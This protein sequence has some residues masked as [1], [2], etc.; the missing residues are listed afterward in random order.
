MRTASARRTTLRSRL[1]VTAVVCV[2]AVAATASVSGIALGNALSTSD[3][4]ERLAE[5]QSRHQDVDMAHD[6]VQAI[7]ARTALAGQRG[8]L[9]T[10][11]DQ[12]AELDRQRL[13]VD[14]ALGEVYELL[15]DEPGLLAPEQQ[16]SGDLGEYLALADRIVNSM[17]G[18]AY[19]Q[20][21]WS[22]FGDA[23]DELEATLATVTEQFRDAIAQATVRGDR[24]KRTAIQV[25]TLA[26]L[27]AVLTIVT[28][29][30]LLRRS[31]ARTIDRMSDVADAV[32][33]G[34]LSRRNA[35]TTEDELGR[36]AQRFDSV[37]ASLDAMVARLTA[38]AARTS[39]SHELSSVLDTVDAE[40]DLAGVAERAMKHATEA[41]VEL[42]LAD[43]SR[44][45]LQRAAGH[46]VHGAPGCG[47]VSPFDCAAVRRGDTVVFRSSEGLDACP[48]LAGRC[49]GAETAVCAPVGFMGRA[50]G[51]LHATRP[52]EEPFTADEVERLG[53][54]ATALGTRV[55]TIRAFRTSQLRAATDG[56]TGLLNRRSLEERLNLLVSELQPF[57]LA[58]ADLD[59]FK[60][61]N[62]TYGHETGDRALRMF[63]EV[64]RT[65]LRSVDL[66]ARWGGEEFTIAF[67][68]VTATEA[69]AACDRVR[70]SL[71][72]AS[73]SGAVP[74]FTVSFGVVDATVAGGVREA[75]RLADEALYAAKNAGRDRVV[76]GPVGAGVVA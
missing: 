18:T 59:H 17:G 75:L 25:L 23:S 37:A 43:S 63:A 4:I 58:V 34:D 16:A 31:L 20:Q 73:S 72:V 33:G 1:A 14:D 27:A 13:V 64:L 11:N 38:D 71:L 3:R 30:V 49:A 26:A 44:A 55:G 5:A 8:D 2:V 50:V 46:P 24:A 48:K 56:L 45:H 10:L 41:K 70:E 62:D 28:A 40:D 7:V 29:L 35:D 67:P 39:F 22:R 60:R 69:A 32:A 66:V 12:R 65:S 76:I 61:L 54:L 19:S 52:D 57:C 6:A 51:V 42:L 9:A 68:G 36:L 21:D 15:V 53:T 47:V 74:G